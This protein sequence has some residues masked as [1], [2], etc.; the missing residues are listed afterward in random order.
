MTLTRIV[1]RERARLAGAIAGAGLGAAV[2]AGLVIV[3]IAALALGQG[4]WIRIPAAPLAVWGGILLLLVLAAALTERALRRRAAPSAVAG[5][6]ERERGLRAG[7]LRAAA[8][9][10]ESG[11]L[12]RRAAEL[13][14]QRVASMGKVLAPAALSGARRGLAL[15][16]VLVALAGAVAAFSATAAPDGWRAMRHPARAL[17]GTLLPPITIT[18]SAGTVLRGDSV[19]LSI[20][21]PQRR[22]VTLYVRM[23]GASW[24]A[25]PVPLTMGAAGVTLRGLDAD[26]TAV[27][28][29]GR[30]LSDT[31]VIRVRDR[32]FVGDVAVEAVYPA[33][34]ARAPEPLAA[35]EPIRVPRGT[36][37]RIEAR[38]S[39]DLSAAGLVREG[40]A[41]TLRF[42]ARGRRA[43]GR[44]DAGAGGSWKWYASGTEGPVAD[45]PPPL[46][47]QT[48]PD[49]APR[50]EILA[51]AADTVLAAD[52]TV[53]LRLAASDDHGL[54][55]A[56]VRSWRETNGRK[57]PA[58]EQLVAQP[59]APAWAGEVPLDLAPRGL[60]PG[61]ALH[62]LFL[63]TDDSPWQ[64]TGQS[65]ELVIRRPTAA[66]ARALARALGDS[67]AART[68]NAA[69]AERDLA[70]RTQEAARTRTDRTTN[71][72]GRRAASFETAERAASLAHA[73]EQLT[74]QVRDAQRD[75]AALE[76]ALQDAG[77]LD[78]TLQRQLREVQKMLSEALTPEMA[79]QLAA[80][81]SASKRLSPEEMRRALEQLAQQQ[82]KL[83]AELERTAGMLRR[84]AL[85]GADADATR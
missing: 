46:E 19:T 82:E 50:A 22:A 2:A 65:R 33:Y 15:G 62:V 41:D 54:A 11:S 23:T 63:V 43:H 40:S 5:A 73:Q 51:P 61:D 52:A 21:A 84:A 70:R 74:Q 68:A 80:V 75:A 36:M 60:E 47:V 69:S 76:K 81:M 17:A 49:A 32:A 20:A 42:T 9:S 35:G 4:R 67:A 39:A 38:A 53:M 55:R 57:M 71:A 8:E 45:V 10:A 78:T 77:A 1:A 56:I 26:V 14:A 3:A 44:L 79:R 13:M 27:V 16:A 66:E 59:G 12:G 18:A 85:E 72:E 7:A 83:R 6:I 37:L 29:D 28:S 48:V 34:L 31:L 64:Q 24:G 58:A 30:A 25:R